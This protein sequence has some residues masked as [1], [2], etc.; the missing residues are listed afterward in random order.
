[1]TQ[2]KKEKEP[3]VSPPFLCAKSVKS[4]D[5]F[6]VRLRVH[7]ASVVNSLWNLCR[8]GKVERARGPMNFEEAESQEASATTAGNACLI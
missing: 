4:A 7:C 2:M 1:M 6:L 8:L 3:F 5:T